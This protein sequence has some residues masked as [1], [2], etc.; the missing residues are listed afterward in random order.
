MVQTVRVR[1]M[2]SGLLPA[3][4]SHHFA[5]LVLVAG[6][7]VALGGVTGTLLL[8][9]VGPLHLAGCLQDYLYPVRPLVIDASSADCLRKIV[10]H[11]PWHSRQVAQITLL[12]FGLLYLHDGHLNKSI[13]ILRSLQ[14]KTVNT[15]QV[16]ANHY[17][18]LLN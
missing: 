10:N 18:I 16:R 7:S 6:G 8:E 14:N 13:S 4:G 15:S 5:V 17:A 2:G 11:R 1:M 3:G 12:P 9:A